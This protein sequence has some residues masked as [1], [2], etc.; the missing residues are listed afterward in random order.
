MAKQRKKKSKSGRAKTKPPLSFLDKF[1]YSVIFV[2]GA[3][4]IIGLYCLWEI[5][6]GE[7]AFSDGSVVAFTSRNTFFY[8]IPFFV[9]LI[10]SLGVGAIILFTIPLFKNKNVNYNDNKWIRVYPL[11]DKTQPR[12]KKREEDKKSNRKIFFCWLCGLLLTFLVLLLALCGRYT[13]N[14]DFMVQKYTVFN[15]VSETYVSRNF[16]SVEFDLMYSSGGRYSG[17]R[18]FS[19]IAD[20]ETKDGKSIVFDDEGFKSDNM[21]EIFRFMLEIKELFPKEKV[22][23]YT[24][25]TIDDAKEWWELTEEET[26]LLKKLMDE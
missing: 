21:G 16:E 13:I 8:A 17:T 20:I 14:D 26:K 6:M 25:R 15:N 9:Y 2:I 18:G 19:L 11:F 24:N 7:I 23:C 5:L 3:L 1:I 4:V 12:P 10:V 22:T